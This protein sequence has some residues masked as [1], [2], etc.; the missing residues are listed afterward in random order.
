MGTSKNKLTY[1]TETK[2][3]LKTAIMNKGVSI[4]EEDTF[5]S[6]PE[7]IN[8]I[9]GDETITKAFLPP[10]FKGG[11]INSK[12]LLI[13]PMSYYNRAQSDFEVNEFEASANI[14]FYPAS[15]IIAGF[16]NYSSP[17]NA[18]YYARDLENNFIFSLEAKR[19]VCSVPIFIKKNTFL[20][21]A[22]IS[23]SCYLVG[24]DDVNLT[25]TYTDTATRL[26]QGAKG[27]TN[28]YFQPVLFLENIVYGINTS[29]LRITML[30]IQTLEYGSIE[31]RASLSDTIA[32]YKKEN[33]IYALQPDKKVIAPLT[34]AYSTAEWT[35]K[36][37]DF[38][39]IKAS[40]QFYDGSYVF[41][42]D[43]NNKMRIFK[44]QD[45]EDG[46]MTWIEDTAKTEQFHNV[47]GL[48]NSTTAINIIPQLDKTVYLQNGSV[49][50]AFEYHVDTDTFQQIEHPCCSLIKETDDVS[51][52]RQGIVNKVDGVCCLTLRSSSSV[53]GFRYA[54]L[55]QTDLGEL[56]WVAYEPVKA[57]YTPDS[58]TVQST[59]RTGTDE[60]GN[61]YL[62]VRG[63]RMVYDLGAVLPDHPN[64]SHT[65]STSSTLG[66]VNEAA[67]WSNDIETE[68]IT[69]SNK[70]IQSERES[71][72]EPA[73][74]SENNTTLIENEIDTTN[75]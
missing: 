26:L 22:G 8:N 66:Q 42:I 48:M 5:R 56:K 47:M 64:N 11:T 53:C 52:I 44:P 58:Q 43:T 6:Y 39:G 30:N 32:L 60:N 9:K 59:G 19:L 70:E 69:E 40:M 4:S 29:N 14:G 3:A 16:W 63:M 21:S 51:T 34:G 67:Q 75:S 7:K 61:L 24:F 13:N 49:F 45:K 68:A 33:I 41:C 54:K 17:T 36:P 62:E 46:S 74:P 10:D 65:D 15:D 28:L 27:L 50:G 72:L 71:T 73:S 38:A 12:I 1:L 55:E 37:S 25:I 2:E 20:M 18:A 23:Y 57:N 35:E 31:T